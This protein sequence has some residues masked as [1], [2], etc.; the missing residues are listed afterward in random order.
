VIA[1]GAWPAWPPESIRLASLD[2]VALPCPRG[3]CPPPAEARE[4]P[5]PWLRA[6]GWLLAREEETADPRRDPLGR[7]AAAYS[8]LHELRV[9]DRPL[10]HALA[11]L[12]RLRL[13]A[14]CAPRGLALERAPRWPGGARFAVVSSLEVT[15]L[16][17]APH[18]RRLRRLARTRSPG[19]LL[20]PAP[21]DPRADGPLDR[22]VATAAEL[23]AGA[24]FLFAPPALAR[25]HA[26]DPLYEPD[27]PVTL[28]GRGIDVATLARALADRGFEIGLLAGF[29]SHAEADALGRERVS[30]EALLSLPVAAVRAIRTRFDVART[31]GA[32]AAAGFST[33]LGLGYEEAGGFRA[34]LAAPFHPWDATRGG[35]H[36][37][38]AVPM[39]ASAG[40]SGAG[41][42]HLRA[43]EEA[44]GLAS[45]GA[46]LGAG[47]GGAAPDPF[48]AWRDALAHAAARG[49][50]LTSA[51][52]VAAW[53]RERSRRLARD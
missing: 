24:T 36:E 46:A 6:V 52:E 45:L 3:V 37:L 53:W 42:A 33:E 47:A 8:R 43:V 2:R 16:P 5:E 10:V 27:D 51:R 15:D 40:S 38:L 29:E 41:V 48:E 22:W 20:A 50:W 35:A 21:A 34:G 39:T 49:A 30:L 26:F 9:L 44:G 25:P 13:E 4:L 12:L 28:E 19:A 7:Y 11:G 31:W 17:L 23:G 32:A 14:W 1:V 18:R